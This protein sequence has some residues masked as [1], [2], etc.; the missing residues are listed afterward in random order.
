MAIAMEY[1]NIVVPKAVIAAKYP[2]GVA[3]CQKEY[4]PSFLEDEYLTRGGAMI[5]FDGQRIIRHLEQFG[6][7]YLDENGKSVE[8]VVVDMI[9]GPTTPCDWVEFDSGKDG[10]RCWLRGTPPGELSKPNRPEDYRDTIVA[11]GKDE[12]FVITVENAV[13]SQPKLIERE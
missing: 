7:R 11:F 1:I 4:G 6:I 9:K 13:P 12:T 2:G 5:W 3:Q 8:I 10:P